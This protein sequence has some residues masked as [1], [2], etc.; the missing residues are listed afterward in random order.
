MARVNLLTFKFLVAAH[1]VLS[2][3][4][5]INGQFSRYNQD[6]SAKKENQSC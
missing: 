3:E 2:K 6:C 4:G 5:G 1:G